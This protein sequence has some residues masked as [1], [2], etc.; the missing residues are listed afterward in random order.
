MGKRI[1][2]LILM[3][4]V[5]YAIYFL[6]AYHIVFIGKNVTLLKK[7]ELTLTDTF[8]N[9]GNRKE[10][11]YKGVD[12]FLRNDSLRDAGIGELLVEKGLITEKELREAEDK[13][14][15]GEE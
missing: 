4:A 12:V 1:K 10:I 15:Y 9:P 8:V 14:D 3:G 6:L 2:Q 7:N 11:L 13:V 5:G